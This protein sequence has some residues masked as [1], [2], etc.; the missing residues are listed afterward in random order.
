MA[1]DP[2]QG[3]D[4][5]EIRTVKPGDRVLRMQSHRHRLPIIERRVGG[6]FIA[7]FDFFADLL[8]QTPV[9]P[10]MAILALL[11]ALAPI[12]IFFLEQA[13]DD[14]QV[15][16]Y[17]VGLWWAVSAFST[18]G[19]SNVELLTVGGRIVGS[20]YTVISVG[21][22]FGS[23]IAAFSSYFLLTWRRPKRQLVDTVNYY[24]QRIDELSV[25]E[26]EDLEDITQG[27]LRTAK[28]RAELESRHS[29]TH[30]E[31]HSSAGE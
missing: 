30:T 20:I 8:T 5:R 11:V 7:A 2:R 22:F 6:P 29:P 16:S 27:L 12:P 17:W 23:V 19:H 14:S 28:D 13:A 25:E 18:V 10:I 15:T 4:P 31:G 1:N 24:L 26:I 3:A 9:L 21:L